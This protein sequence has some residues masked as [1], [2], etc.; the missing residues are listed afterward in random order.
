ML[1]TPRPWHEPEGEGLYREKVIYLP[2]YPWPQAVIS[3]H[4]FQEAGVPGA[5]ARV[6]RV[7]PPPVLQADHRG[8]EG[9]VLRAAMA[10]A[11]QVSGQSDGLVTTNKWAIRYI[12]Y[13]SGLAVTSAG[14]CC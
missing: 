6:R 1:Q 10:G 5:R 13:I 8:R 11:H 9:K 3:N 4:Y 7:A 12:C 2:L 14:A